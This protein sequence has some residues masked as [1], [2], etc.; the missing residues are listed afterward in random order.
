MKKPNDIAVLMGGQG[1]ERE[2][3]I[4]SGKAIQSALETMGYNV[5]AITLENKLVDI[6]SDLHS[7]DLVFLGLHG[8][9]G[10]NGTIQ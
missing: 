4:K 9:I 3:S 7:V 5:L 8:S 6:I 10:E 1:E 2:I